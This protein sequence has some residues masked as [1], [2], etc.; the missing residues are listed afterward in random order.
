MQSDV[1]P[2]SLVQEDVADVLY[3]VAQDDASVFVFPLHMEL[4]SQSVFSDYYDGGART[5]SQHS[6]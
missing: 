4:C 2:F 1:D 5:F 3:E 6:V